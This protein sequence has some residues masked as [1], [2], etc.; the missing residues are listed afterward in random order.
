MNIIVIEVNNLT[1]KFNMAREKTESLKEYF[2]K[3]AKRQL[4]YD[5]FLALNNVS[6]SVGKGEAMGILGANGSG[7][8][9][10]LKCVSGIYPPTS[11]TISICGTIAPMIELGAGFDPELTAREN[12]FLNG[13]VMGFSKQFIE[14]KFEQIVDFSELHKFLDVPVKNF[15]SGMGARLGFS[16]ATL[17]K[18]DILIIDEVLAVGDTAFQKKCETKMEELR[19]DGTTLLF[20]SHSIPQVKKLCDKAIWLIKGKKVMEGAVQQVCQEYEE[21]SKVHSAFE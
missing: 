18:P 5:E 8:S 7:K 10:L 20:V 3:L 11:G 1:M 14:D 13:A 12:I 19:A 16:I 9:T 6:F 15:S 4:F 21:W 17:V 2:V